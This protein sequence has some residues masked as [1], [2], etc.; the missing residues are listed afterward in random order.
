VTIDEAVIALR[1][2][3]EPLLSLILRHHEANIR[4]AQIC[5]R[6]HAQPEAERDWASVKAERDQCDSVFT[7]YA[8]NCSRLQ[9]AYDNALADLEVA[10]LGRQYSISD[11]SIL[12]VRNHEH[13]DYGGF[14]RAMCRAWGEAHDQ[15][16]AKARAE[17][18][19]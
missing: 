14:T 8:R 2:A 17:L 18:A 11:G 1:K 3:E 10:I 19:K 15:A 9:A 16:E 13:S 5:G 12:P 7:E 6:M 4:D